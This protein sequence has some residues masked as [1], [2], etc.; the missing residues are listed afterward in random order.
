MANIKIDFKNGKAKTDTNLCDLKNELDGHYSSTLFGERISYSFLGNWNMCP[1]GAYFGLLYPPKK[2]WFFSVGQAVHKM[3]ENT[4]NKVPFT[5]QD[6]LEN[7]LK[8]YEE[9]LPKAKEYFQ[10][11]F[12]IEDTPRD[13]AEFLTEYKIKDELTICGQTIGIKG[14]VDRID[15]YDDKVRVI[16]YKTASKPITKLTDGHKEQLIMYKMGVEHQMNTK[17]DELAIIGLTSNRATVLPYTPS[18]SDEAS[19]KKK[20]MRVDEQLKDSISN[21]SFD[22]CPN[23]RCKSCPLYTSCKNREEVEIE[24]KAC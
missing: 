4:F 7:E 11:Y 23:W 10:S 12:S 6:I 20:L 17:V 5:D 8:G 1:A 18:L 14:F 3:L 15:K 9:Y 21:G 19:F 22:F 24:C 2:F 16:D 13:K